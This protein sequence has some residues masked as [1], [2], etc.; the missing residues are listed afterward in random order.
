MNVCMCVVVCVIHLQ[1]ASED[2]FKDE[3]QR[4]KTLQ[5]SAANETDRL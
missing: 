5:G 1:Q 3:M 4:Y 2:E